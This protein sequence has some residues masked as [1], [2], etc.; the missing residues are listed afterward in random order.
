MEVVVEVAV[1]HLLIEV[2]AVARGLLVTLLNGRRHT[3]LT[4]L[5]LLLPRPAAAVV[6][7][8]VAVVAAPPTAARM[9]RPELGADR[10][11]R[12]R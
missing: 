7:A 11:E 10:P 6:N 12:R 3:A 9:S 4:L 2:A 5:L 1:S 8:T